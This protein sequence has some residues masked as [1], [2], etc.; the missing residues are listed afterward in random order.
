M[1][2]CCKQNILNYFCNTIAKIMGKSV[3]ILGLLFTSLA[4]LVC[5]GMPIL[6]NLIGGGIGLMLLI[7]PYIMYLTFIQGG[8]LGWSFYRLYGNKVEKK[9]KQKIEKIIFWLI[10]LLTIVALSVHGK[11][12]KTEEEQLKQRKFELFFDKHSSR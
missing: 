3:G 8:I 11:I 2:Q 9:P 4:H 6:M 7:Q 5:C 10:A 1:Q 12:I